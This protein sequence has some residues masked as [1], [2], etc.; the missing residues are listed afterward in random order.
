[1]SVLS[2][3]AQMTALYEHC[4]QMV[5]LMKRRE[6][7]IYEYVYVNPAALEIFDMSPIGKT[8]QEVHLSEATI[9]TVANYYEQS[10]TENR[11]VTYRD[12]YLYA[13]AK[14][15]NET[16]VWPVNML[17]ATYLLAISKEMSTHKV[18]EEEQY[19]L[20]TLFLKQ[21]NPMIVITPDGL[22]L[23]ANKIFSKVFDTEDKIVKGQHLK[24][25]NEHQRIEFRRLTECVQRLK[26]GNTRET[27]RMHW[28][29]D[30]VEIQYKVVAIPII[31]EKKLV[32][33]SFE[34]IEQTDAQHLEDTLKETNFLL[35]SYK[36][37]LESATNFC[38]TDPKG[39]IEYVSDGYVQLTGYGP[40]E[41]IGKTNSLLNSRQHDN[42]FFKH[43]WETINRGEIWKGEICNR[44]KKGNHYWVHTTIVP[45]R[46]K[47]DHIKNFVSIC[48][49]ITERR[50]LLSSLQ[51]IEKTFKLITENTNDF[52]SI[53]NEDGII[54]YVSPNHERYLGY[55]QDQLIGK[56]YI[57]ILADESS[58]LLRR[59][60]RDALTKDQD[61]N[62]EVEMKA[63][64]G[65]TIWAEAYITGVQDPIREEVY[66]FVSI[67][68][69]ITERK[70]KED[71]LRFLAY[72]DA[73]TMLPNR[74]YL[75]LQS[76]NIEEEAEA[77]N[78]SIVVMY[79]DGDNFK[80]IN[81]QYGHDVGDEFIRQFGRAL[82][83]SVRD[84]DFVCRIGGDEFV[85]VLTRMTRNPIT[86]NI[87]ILNTI[88]RI[89]KMLST[90]WEINGDHFSP[91]SSIGI[92]TYPEHGRKIEELLEKADAA[93]YLAK[94]VNGK[95]SYR[96]AEQD[97]F[98]RRQD[99]E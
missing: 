49:D 99:F 9:A 85:V 40:C 81:D 51:S 35:E 48:V 50:A 68:R 58:A 37:A 15:T 60:L 10:F 73:L 8:L 30:G 1:M 88:N 76:A 47:D 77:L 67:A 33:I 42:A 87:Q 78:Q 23:K 31:M 69:E 89:Q 59:E 26:N 39:V 20:S 18:L 54:L 98:N 13:D 7:S 96:F 5:F 61:L 71:E 56:F 64:N 22:V 32:A 38:I 75:S 25:Y 28:V 3:E 95:D 21:H 45:I 84:S 80:A 36:Q 29:Y 83:S 6:P 19:F 43:L 2:I 57:D 52:I 91:T 93:L 63:K 24:A 53:T 66:Q 4:D 34:W 44:A 46:D 82:K 94:N 16:T 65:D 55:S 27:L 92:A 41:L 79:I 74:R 11:Q 72:H 97:E 90:G 12:F 17:D 62:I 70:Q 14:Y 86:R